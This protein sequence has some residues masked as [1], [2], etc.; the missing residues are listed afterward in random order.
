MSKGISVRSGQNFKEEE[1]N[2][3]KTTCL[4]LD[5]KQ[6]KITRAMWTKA[7]FYTP[8]IL[9]NIKKFN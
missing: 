6:N 9:L 3:Q 8:K 7:S 5:G 2:L 1:G 4:S